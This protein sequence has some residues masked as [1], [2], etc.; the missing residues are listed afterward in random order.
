MVNKNV[1][2]LA[3][4][5]IAAIWCQAPAFADLIDP[6]NP[7]L[8]PFVITQG[9]FKTLSLNLAGAFTNVDTIV[10]SNQMNLWVLTNTG[11]TNGSSVIDNPYNPGTGTATNPPSDYYFQTGLNTTTGGLGC[12]PSCNTFLDPSPTFTAQGDTT[13]TWDAN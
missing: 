4:A 12:T 8:Q 1:K 11:Q 2:V 3:A 5:A 9:D 6:N 13:N 7:T 10:K